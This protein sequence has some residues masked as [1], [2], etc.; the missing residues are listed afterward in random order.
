MLLAAQ[1][2]AMS[3]IT[4]LVIVVGKAVIFLT[5]GHA[6]QGLSVQKVIKP[7]WFRVLAIYCC[8][9]IYPH[10]PGVGCHK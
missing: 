4:L 9:V 10:D 6:L 3:I 2:V 5:C 8:I 7:V 1:K